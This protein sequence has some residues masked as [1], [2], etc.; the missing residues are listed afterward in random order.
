MQIDSLFYNLTSTGRL[1]QKYV[2]DL[3][4]LTKTIIDKRRKAIAENP[5]I[6]HNGK[7]KSFLDIILTETRSDGTTFTDK[8]LFDQVN[9]TCLCVLSTILTCCTAFIGA[10]HDTTAS[11][12]IWCL[13]LLGHH[14]AIQ[15]K[16]FDEIEEVIGSEGYVTLDHLANMKYLDMVVKEGLRIYPGVPMFARELEADVEV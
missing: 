9:S 3:N 2:G 7:R 16:L 10:G 5:D 12:T 11:S 13:Q 6:V 8:D 15:Q 14:Q 4:A 1:M